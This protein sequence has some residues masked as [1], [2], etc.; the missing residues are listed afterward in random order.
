VKVS[1]LSPSLARTM[2]GTGNLSS[3][4]LQQLDE[5]QELSADPSL[6]AAWCRS[7]R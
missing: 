1:C 4:A 3:I 7:S 2:S 5:R 6:W